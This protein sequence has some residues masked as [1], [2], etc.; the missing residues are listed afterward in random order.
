METNDL[1]KAPAAATSAASSAAQ[2]NSMPHFPAMATQTSLA[3][4]PNVLFAQVVDC[5]DQ[6]IVDQPFALTQRIDSNRSAGVS[7]DNATVSIP[8]VVPIKHNIV[9]R[10]TA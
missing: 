2:V 5:V 3:F 6:F 4:I 7:G 1:V 10:L 8:I 9:Y